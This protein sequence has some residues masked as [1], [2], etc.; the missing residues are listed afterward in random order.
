MKENEYQ[1]GLKKRIKNEFPGCYL[2]K[3]D[4]IDQQGIPDLLV[5]YQDKWCAL[6]CKRS[7][8]APHRPNQD[9]YVSDMNTKG[10]ASFIY[11]E[12]EDDII[13]KML[14]T[15]EDSMAA[16]Q[17]NNHKNIEGLHSALSPSQLPGWGNDDEKFRRI[18]LS[19][20][21]IEK[22]TRLHDLASRLIKEGVNLPKSAKTLN[23]F[24][25]DAI[26]YQMESEV[27]LYYSSNAF[28][29]TDAISFR[30]GLLRVHDYK[31]GVTKASMKQLVAY[32]AYFVWSRNKPSDIDKELRIYQ[33]N[34]VGVYKPN[35]TEILDTME[36][37]IRFDRIAE[38]LKNG[39]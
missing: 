11:P 30:R 2:F 20:L 13:F 38:E 6:E 39:E 36:R 28:G 4:P 31:S 16:F 7:A 34:E 24:V 37:I 9:Y 5:A 21:A 12:N 14:N 1:K 27:P 35:D 18:Y 23:L 15:L 25:N 29:T 3:N 32:V 8:A 19:R 33:N 22:G 10:M 26:G 17:F